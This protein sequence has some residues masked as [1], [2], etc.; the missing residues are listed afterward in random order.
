MFRPL[1]PAMLA[2]HT[3]C[4]VVLVA[5]TLVPQVGS[6][7]SGGDGSIRSLAP[8]YPADVAMDAFQPFVQ[9]NGKALRVGPRAAAAADFDG[10]GQKDLWFLGDA[11]LPGQVAVQFANTASL[12]RFYRRVPLATSTY[13]HAATYHSNSSPVDELILIDPLKD[14]PVLLHWNPLTPKSDPRDGYLGGSGSGWKIGK[15]LKEIATADHSGDGHDDIVTL[16]TLP[17]N[18]TAVDKL[19]MGTSTYNF[20]WVEQRISLVL[21][22]PLEN[23]R[24][25]D[26]DDDKRTDFVASSPGIGIIACR[27]NGAGGFDVAW[28]RTLSDL[29]PMF[30]IAVGDLD[31]NK[32]DDIAMC[33]GAG[34]LVLQFHTSGTQLSTSYRVLMNPKTVGT[35][36][37]CCIIDGD[38]NGSRL[39]IGLP[40][41]GRN[42]VIH[43]D[44]P[45][46]YGIVEP[47]VEYAPKS[48]S[49]PGVLR[50]S[51]IVT[52]VDNDHDPDL[53]LQA[54]DG[55]NWLTLRNPAISFAPIALTVEDKGPA[56]VGEGRRLNVTVT[57]PPQ[58]IQEGTLFVEMAMFVADPSSKNA[59][60]PEYLYWGRVIPAID[61]IR[62]TASFT[63][64]YWDQKAFDAQ[65]LLYKKHRA[66]GLNTNPD[67]YPPNEP[68]TIRSGPHSFMSLHG[69]DAGKRYE[70][71]NG[72]S[73]IETGSTLGG[74]WVL[75]ARPPSPKG[76]I[77]L[78]PWE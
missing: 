25:L 63:V 11:S 35:L 30:D 73:P 39:V 69:I 44:N 15:G 32:Q 62:R 53:V 26:L 65:V 57:V 13:V 59:K 14:D 21:P 29:P 5:G 56:P 70:S 9:D 19:V 55:T 68:E 43:P 67:V 7:R 24:L 60:D 12:G 22:V 66:L 31:G 27:D 58:L 23:L 1:R 76:D 61:V 38:N 33:F 78:L 54:P 41:D 28:F 42:Y 3:A 71:S 34:V 45:A 6:G 40:A 16:R 48:L 72:N 8:R 17:G 52:D 49:G 37:T 74:K 46:K 77:D 64:F 51:V 4:A 20:L 50:Q 36:A 10:D 75:M 2:I 47:W 18:Q